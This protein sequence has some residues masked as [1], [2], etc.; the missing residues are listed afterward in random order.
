[1]LSPMPSLKVNKFRGFFYMRFEN[2]Y[3]LDK[4][5]PMIS[6]IIRTANINREF[7]LNMPNS[8]EIFLSFAT[9]GKDGDSSFSE[10]SGNLVLG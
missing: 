1:M 6:N 3:Q 8:P 4:T 10:S 5:I 7:N 2:E 9:P